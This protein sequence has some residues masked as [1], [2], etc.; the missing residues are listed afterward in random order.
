MPKTSMDKLQAAVNKAL[1][2]YADDVTYTLQD[3]SKDFAKKGAQAIRQEA[4]S[5]GWGEHTG[6]ASG[7]TSKFETGRLS[8]QGII[9]NSKAPGLPHLLE[10]GHAKRNGGRVPG[11][12][13]IAP[14][15]EEI[16]AAFEEAVKHEI[17]GN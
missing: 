10:K 12:P 8:A 15:E 2:T 4:Q 13:H 3:L 9:Y 1:Q 11:I 17:S 5:K 7:W 6:Y 14:V 16:T